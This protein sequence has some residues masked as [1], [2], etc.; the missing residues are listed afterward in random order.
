M[1]KLIIE[2]RVNEY[3]SRRRNARVPWLADE[4]A[5]DAAECRQAGASILH[6]HGR[7]ADGAPDHRFECYRDIMLAAR[8]ASDLLLHPT[9]GAA[10]LDAPAA[11]RIA[12]VRRLAERPETRPDFAPMD[13]GSV[14]FDLYDPAAKRYATSGVIYRNGTDT[15]AHFAGAI[16]G[17][18]ITPYLST[19]TVG[20]MRQIG[21]F[22]DMGLLAAPAFC[23][24]ILTGDILPAGH[25]GTPAGL[26]AH[27]PFL[28]RNHRVEWAACHYNGDLLPLVEKI[29]A[30]GGHV[31]IGLGDWP[32]EEYGRPS[33]AELVHRV[34]ETARRLGRGVAS[35][36]E[37]RAILGMPPVI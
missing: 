13:M 3:A 26:D 19:W 33:N 5:R 29:I 18:G 34:A 32:Y 9:L 16:R 1:Q 2:A 24:F 22:L 8:A 27:T 37:T 30:E 11:A 12:V 21:T 35:V 10:E 4:I 31:S 15:L 36:E 25:P 23:C 14:N 20:A 7:A 6:F 28:P 17:A